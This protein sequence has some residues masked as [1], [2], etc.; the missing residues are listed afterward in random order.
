LVTISQKMT[1]RPPKAGQPSANQTRN[2]R[3]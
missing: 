3:S 1:I 2:S